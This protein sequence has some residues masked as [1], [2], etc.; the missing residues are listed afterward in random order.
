[1]GLVPD[2]FDLLA[3]LSDYKLELIVLR[4]KLLHTEGFGIVQGLKLL[5]FKFEEV[6]LRFCEGR[7]QLVVVRV[8]GNIFVSLVEIHRDSISAA[9]IL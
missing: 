2:G 4:L 5:L 8:E 6:S 3:H 1:M 9:A 7:I